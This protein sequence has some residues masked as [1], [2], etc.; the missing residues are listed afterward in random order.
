MAREQPLAG[1]D[2]GIRAVGRAVEALRG[3]AP[4]QDR[5]AAAAAALVPALAERAEVEILGAPAG[6]AVSGANGGWTEIPLIT[7]GGRPVGVL[8]LGGRAGDPPA[9]LVELAEL[10]AAHM[11]SAVEL[12]GLR[13]GAEDGARAHDDFLATLSHELRTPLN[14]VVGWV[15]LLRRGQL[16]PEKH[17]RAL[18]LID[19]NARVQTRL[20]D[21]LLDV[22]R[23][24]AGR[25]R[26]EPRTISGAELVRG[27]VEALRPQ[28]AEVDL[29]I[30]LRVE[31]D[32][33]LRADPERLGQIL[34]NL[35]G[36]AIK[37]TPAGGRIEV[38]LAVA[39]ADALIS[40]TDTGQGIAP[41]LLPHL[42]DRFVQGERKRLGRTR[43]LGLGL[44]I[45][46]HL[47][48]MHGGDV[49]AE[50]QGPGQGA[51]FTVRLPL[52][53]PA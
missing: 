45:A 29:T 20:M 9:V 16:P 46:R 33:E 4:L 12:A 49:T 23:M 38:A 8:R 6:P 42:F 52:A 13:A 11:A 50:S 40:V 2:E 14:V 19:R 18:E 53:G 35:V 10:A 47:A 27:A 37:F 28:A 36:N 1:V 32:P 15:D 30:D 24:M 21:D 22:S 44:F 5:L 25:L 3:A 26:L 31:A 43:G 41:D 39:G 48:R 34:H 17:G 51:R 7:P